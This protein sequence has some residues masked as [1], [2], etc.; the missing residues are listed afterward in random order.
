M[1]GD[2]HRYSLVRFSLVVDQGLNSFQ[3]PRTRAFSLAGSSSL[4]QWCAGRAWST[5]TK[6]V[7]PHL[8]SAMPELSLSVFKTS[9]ELTGSAPSQM[10]KMWLSHARAC[11]WFAE[12]RGQIWT[13]D[14]SQ[15]KYVFH[16][17]LRGGAPW[18][19]L[20]ALSF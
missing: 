11:L 19:L 8:T 18:F 15:G 17:A 1:P 13:S 7:A 6:D 3:L 20:P 9:R 5:P 16:I 12:H 4:V 10:E 14:R 2:R